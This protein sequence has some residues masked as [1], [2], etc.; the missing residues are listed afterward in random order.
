MVN[1]PIT[2]AAVSGMPTDRA[3]AASAVAS[4]SRQVGVS[5]GVAL[6]GSVAGSAMAIAGADFADCGQAAMAD[7]RGTRPGDHRPGRLLDVGA[8]IALRRAA[9]A[10]G[11]WA[12]RATRGC[13]CQ[14]VDL[15]DEVWR[16]MA[17]PG[18]RQPRRVEASGGRTDRAAVQQ[19]SH[20]QA[21]ESP[22]ADDGEA[23]RPCRGHG[24]ACDDGGDQR[25]RRPRARRA[26][27][28]SDQSAVQG[29]LA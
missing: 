17:S 5:L 20:P 13:R 1:A 12:G 3:G 10:P 4:T 16:A 9:R 25:P 29:R 2:N 24:C 7:L 8:G 22:S 21:A 6:C 27:D 19:D 14:V 26:R 18:D 28:R 23:G 11:G 15:V